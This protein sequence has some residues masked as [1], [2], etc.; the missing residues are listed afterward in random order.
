MQLFH[1]LLFTLFVTSASLFAATPPVQ[2]RTLEPLGEGDWQ[3]LFGKMPEEIVQISEGYS[4]ALVYKVV[5]DGK[6]RLVRQSAAIYGDDSWQQEYDIQKAAADLKLGPAIYQTQLYRHLVVGEFI[7][8]VGFATYM[9]DDPAGR[10]RGIAE[11]IRTFH[12]IPIKE[13]YEDRH[14]ADLFEWLYEMIPENFPEPKL[15]ALFERAYNTPWPTDLRVLSHNDLHP[16]NFLYDG[17]KLW[18]IDWDLA[19]PSHP[20]YDLAYVACTHGLSKPEGLE[21]LEAYLQRPPSE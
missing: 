3:L 18:M 15:R 17:Q 19:R 9:Q 6:P 1:K 2:M 21:L 8:D 20:Y 16:R 10:L 14:T 11:M 13:S 7:H 12:S 4:G 5:V